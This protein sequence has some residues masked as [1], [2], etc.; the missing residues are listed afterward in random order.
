MVNKMSAIE[1]FDLE[2]LSVPVTEEA[3]QGVIKALESGKVVCFPKLN[4][5]LESAESQFLSPSILKPKSKNVSYDLRN[6]NLKGTSCV[7]QDSEQ[8]KAMIK[9]FALFSHDLL[10]NLFPIYLPELDQART[11]YRPIE[12]AGRTISHR[13]DD[14]LLHVDAF[15]SNPVKGHRILRVFT[16]INP[17]GKP[18]VWKV[19]EPFA[20][21]IDKMASRVKKPFPGL[22][23]LLKTLRLT[24]EYRTLY[25]HY[26]LQ[27]HDAMKNDSEYQENV[28]QQEVQFPA[29]STW[30]V[31]TDQVSHAVLS[32]QYVLEQTFYLPPSS[33]K[34][35]QQSPLRMLEKKLS[36]RL[37]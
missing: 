34:Y 9:R 3:I 27:I 24:K 6:N 28:P 10:K 12:A 4:F 35:E 33:M 23:R 17:E 37:V 18:R 26:M 11:S 25:D 21:V 14:T 8:L 16:N 7:G 31:Y 13:K 1:T 5:N 36:Q 30:M 19:G 32:G 20:D 2:T 29:G 15:P 22:S